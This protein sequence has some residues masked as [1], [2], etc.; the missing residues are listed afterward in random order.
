MLKQKCLD[1]ASSGLKTS[2]TVR[3]VS[4]LAQKIASAPD[5]QTKRDK[6]IAAT[7][8]QK[9]RETFHS[10]RGESHE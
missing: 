2:N 4:D 9:G 1:E 7:K 10:Q 6:G 5:R 3:Q 8:G